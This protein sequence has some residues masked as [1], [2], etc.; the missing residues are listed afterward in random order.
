MNGNFYFDVHGHPEGT[1]PSGWKIA[2][3]FRMPKDV[4]I[5]KLA[6]RGI[7][8]V[9]CAI[10]D[11]GSFKKNPGDL[12]LLTKRQIERIRQKIENSNHRPI[13]SSA[14]LE[15]ARKSGECAFLIGIEGGD[16][17]GRKIE[18]LKEIYALGVRLLVPVHYSANSFGSIEFGWKGRL[19]PES[20]RGGLTD[21]GREIIVEANR[22]GL[23]LDLAHAD[24]KTL[25]ESAK[26]AKA[27]IICS[28]T[29]PLGLQ[30]FPR[31]ISDESIRRIADS[32]GIIGLWPF[33]NKGLGMAD[34]E[35]F[36][37]AALYIR[38]KAGIDALA[39]GT[40]FNGVPGYMKG[41][42]NVSQSG[43]LEKFLSES[44][45]SEEEIRKITGLNFIRVFR[46][47][48]AGR[49]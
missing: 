49:T 7:G 6:K 15:T 43:L 13:L 9:L 25:I 16:F 24:D 12:F 1:I 10:G 34:S 28:H 48:E 39:I 36:K 11:A 27:P 32:G 20:E 45:F 40:D 35:S 42:A 5:A 22:L 29:G 41:F 26:V 3:F 19:I 37:K 21:F 46:D 38:D 8:G 14:E 17:I 47:V 18:I 31:Y 4:G 33:F 30:N 2:S 23:I 44:G